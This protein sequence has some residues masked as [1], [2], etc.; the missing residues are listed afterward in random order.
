MEGRV[1]WDSSLSA[2]LHDLYEVFMSF[3]GAEDAVLD[4]CVVW[5][6]RLIS[7]GVGVFA[8]AH[9][10]AYNG[11]LAAYYVSSNAVQL[12]SVAGLRDLKAQGGKLCVYQS[13]SDAVYPMLASAVPRARLV[14]M[15]NYG[16]MLEKLLTGGC[17]AAL[18]GK[19]EAA[20]YIRGANVNF[21]VCKDPADP[22]GLATCADKTRP[23]AA[24]FLNPATCPAGACQYARRYCSLVA[25]RDDAVAP[26]ALSFAMPLRADL[27]PAVGRASHHARARTHT[28]IH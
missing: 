6:S 16:P 7:L 13:M 23:P 8:F 10:L 12:G 22:R 9:V 26:I 15:D 20:F 3:L 18:V 17:A 21:T 25:L 27:E 5:P 14:P 1:S 11:S 28:H 2:P 24:V 4:S 19:Y